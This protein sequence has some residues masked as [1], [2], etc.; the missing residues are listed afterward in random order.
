MDGVT[1]TLPMPPS[2]GAS[3]YIPP[4]QG[5]FAQPPP[6]TVAQSAQQPAAPRAVG[7][8]SGDPDV[9]EQRAERQQ[10]KQRLK[11]ILPT[12][13]TDGRIAVFRLEGR[14][15]KTKGN[16]GRPV[17]IILWR[18]LEKAVK[19]DGYADTGDY[20]RDKLLEKYSKGRFLLETHDNKGRM[21]QEA[22]DAEI[23][24]SDGTDNPEEDPVNEPNADVD[25]DAP[26]SDLE[27]Q[28]L[29]QAPAP[30]PFDAAVHAR[31]VQE[32]VREEKRGSESMVTV[33]LTM[34]QTQMQQ[35]AVAAQQAAQ[36]AEA[37]RLEEDRRRDREE[38]KEREERRLE[39]ERLRLEQERREK[40]E[41][42]R[43]DRERERRTAETQMQ[44]QFFQTIMTNMNKEKTDTV[45]PMLMKMIENKG[46]RDGMKEVFN[47]LGEQ[48]KQSML[49]QAEGTRHL[50]NAQ[51]E[52]NKVIMQN[53][54]GITQKM[55]EN[56]ATAQEDPTD[57]P[58]EKIGRVFKMLAPALSMMGSG[59]QQTVATTARVV[60][61]QP[62]PQMVQ[63]P[64]EYV[65]G[66]LYTIMR[67]ETGQIH[68]RQR[69]QALNWCAINLP[70]EVLDAIR[71]GD[72]ST[73]LTIGANAMDET[74]KA[75]AQDMD[76]LGFLR[77]CIAD[78]QRILLGA[79]TQADARASIERHIAYMQAK[80]QQMQQAPQQPA[81]PAQQPA[82]AAEAA[83]PV[84][85]NESQ[86]AQP[87]PSGK[88]RA[89]PAAEPTPPAAP[90][91]TPAAETPPSSN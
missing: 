67:L 65:K 88:R 29:P 56:M 45:T 15:G 41:Q 60:Q 14:R 39:L 49:T 38:A 78:I 75:W 73:V 54:M 22:G 77:E 16:H 24:L 18:D 44:M 25:L 79:L 89:P 50:M 85:I 10:L 21:M 71:A 40:E 57:D 43:D 63:P 37:R 30:P 12:S 6:P 27:R 86:L 26:L 62:T 80:G 81:Q 66:A 58:V 3:A 53:V 59:T 13:M 69:W 17:L 48:S 52:G 64:I 2:P 46:D 23:D 19:E 91:A 11:D 74:L 31:T 76:H 8:P 82:T 51:V 28:P 72:E 33:I 84:E 1:P 68:V 61:Q 36:Q 20:V 35:Q 42:R 70:K 7:R 87:A 4:A 34:M 5:G 9:N 90:A 32:L 83:I 47:L 55:V